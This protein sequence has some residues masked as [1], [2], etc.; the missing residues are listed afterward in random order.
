MAKQIVLI[1]FLTAVFTGLKG[2]EN[3]QQNFLVFHNMLMKPDTMLFSFWKS[4]DT[5]KVKRILHQYAPMESTG[6]KMD[7]S[8][9]QNQRIDAVEGSKLF[10]GK[11]IKYRFGTEK[12]LIRND[13]LY[14]FILTNRLSRDSLDVLF[15][16]GNNPKYFNKLEYQNN[17]EIIKRNRIRIK[18]V[19]FYKGMFDNK[20]EHLIHGKKCTDTIH[21]RKQWKIEGQSFYAIALNFNCLKYPKSE[22]LIVDEN[23]QI[24]AFGRKYLSTEMTPYVNI[25]PFKA[26]FFLKQ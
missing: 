11:R 8:F 16:H 7:F 24:H 25:K 21:L 15:G 1:I 10:N 18:K 12:Y 13:T 14:K 19:L 3:Y 20:K 6:K 26:R 9:R 4:G 17:L 2:Q 22:T 23:F 5:M